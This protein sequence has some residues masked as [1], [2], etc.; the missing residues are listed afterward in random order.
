MGCAA[1]SRGVGCVACIVR[2]ARA[3][4]RCGIVHCRAGR[5]A[6]G[7]DIA[8][9]LGQLGHGGVGE[10][11]HAEARGGE[12]RRAQQQQPEERAVL[13]L[14]RGGLLALLRAARHR[15]GLRIIVRVVRERLALRWAHRCL[16]QELV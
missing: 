13:C 1:C 14:G 5:T 12:Q 10:R 8:Q 15:V 4:Y 11:D 2:R 9:E 7:G 3:A 6:E 16:A